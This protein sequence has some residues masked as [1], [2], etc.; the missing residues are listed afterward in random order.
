MKIFIAFL[1]IF[2][3]FSDGKNLGDPA[4]PPA[5]SSTAVPDDTTT[6]SAFA[7]VSVS[8]TWKF[9]S[10]INT[11]NVVMVIKNLKASQWAGVG[12]GQNQSMNEA[13]VFICKRLSNDTIDINRYINPGDYNPP[14]P[15]GSEQGGVFT[16]LPSQFTDGVVI[17]QFN[18]SN[19]PTQPFKQIQ[20]LRPLSQSGDY[21]PIIAVGPLDSNNTIHKHAHDS[22]IALPGTVQLDENEIIRYKLTS[23]RPYADPSVDSA[24][25]MT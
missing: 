1:L 20:A 4:M 22:R 18:L 8:V 2:S 17:C 9:S 5:L 7:T 10:G 19:F 16:P 12:L 11:T 15:A 14:K 3:S 25:I 24:Y 6:T 23:P 13:H 21:Y